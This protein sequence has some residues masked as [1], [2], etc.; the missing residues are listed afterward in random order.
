MKI[1]AYLP[2]D[3]GKQAKDAE[4][5]LSGMLR[6]AVQDELLRREAVAHLTQAF[7]VFELDLENDIGRYTGRLTG[8][9][10]DEN[11]YFTDDERLI[12]HDQNKVIEITNE[13]N[14]GCYFSDADIY[15][16]AMG[17]IGKRAVI[18]L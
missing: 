10:L 7:R 14:I 1:N 5:P 15:Q 11:V 9:Q 2:D 18:G 8:V 16:I 4:L 17:K 12:Y 13:D 6:Q 3:I